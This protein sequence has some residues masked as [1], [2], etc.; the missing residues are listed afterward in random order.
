[1]GKELEWEQF[2]FGGGGLVCRRL[3]GRR[4]SL[5]RLREGEGKS[6]VAEREEVVLG[7]CG[8]GEHLLQVW[9]SPGVAGGC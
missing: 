7:S 4:E 9:V 8:E 6:V 1:M 2:D 3:K 5:K